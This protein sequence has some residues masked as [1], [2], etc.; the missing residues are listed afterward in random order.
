VRNSNYLKMLFLAFLFFVRPVEAANFDKYY[1]CEN[2]ILD[3]SIRF[4][5][6]GSSATLD[7]IDERMAF[8]QDPQI[9][10]E[11]GYIKNYITQ[12]DFNI[13]SWRQD[14]VNQIYKNTNVKKVFYD[15]FAWTKAKDL[16]DSNPLK[17]CAVILKFEIELP[18][19][20]R[21]SGKI[22]IGRY[23]TYKDDNGTLSFKGPGKPL[24]YPF[25]ARS[26]SRSFSTYLRN[27]HAVHNEVDEIS[28]S[29]LNSIIDVLGRRKK[30]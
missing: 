7:D 26:Q 4:W 20:A 1:Q 16:N 24:G 27:G 15:S 5:Y 28:L 29:L 19:P 6:I 21:I 17:A 3:S 10:H 12:Y 25:F 9:Q 18:S 8:T 30:D 22:E 2:V 13:N 23:Y 14:I 11:L